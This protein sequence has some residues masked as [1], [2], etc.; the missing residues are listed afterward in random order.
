MAKQIKLTGNLL[1]QLAEGAQ[2]AP[3]PL[4]FDMSGTEQI[5]YGFNHLTPVSNQL[6]P[7][8]SVTN[9]RF[10]LVFLYEGSISL[11]WNVAGDGATVLS[12]NPTPPPSDR[13]LLMLFRYNAPASSLYL[14]VPSN[15]RGEIWM[16]E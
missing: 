13:P 10:I 5:I 2:P 6:V 9:P 8:G 12:A 15:A 11:A 7:A 4:S 1:V 16:F 14:T 3:I